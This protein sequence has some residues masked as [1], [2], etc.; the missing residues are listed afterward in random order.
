MNKEVG[1]GARSIGQLLSF[2]QIPEIKYNICTAMKKNFWELSYQDLA[3]ALKNIAEINGVEIL[4]DAML[5]EANVFLCKFR[6]KRFN[7][8]FDLDYG[9]EIKPVDKITQ[10]DLKRIEE[11]ILTEVK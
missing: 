1:A 11:L 9:A 5:S 6:G 4:E 10:E 7:I 3:F 2:Y 8:Y